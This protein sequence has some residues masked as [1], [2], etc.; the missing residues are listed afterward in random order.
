MSS[1]F[2]K[3]EWIMVSEQANEALAFVKNDGLNGRSAAEIAV[4][5]GCTDMIVGDIGD[6]ALGRLQDAK[7]HV[8]AAQLPLTGGEALKMFRDG[9]LSPV[10]A[11][12]AATRHGSG[13]GCC[14]KSEAGSEGSSCCR[15]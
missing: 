9:Q 15:G 10:P 3:A 1:H 12:R 13:H 4:N 5:Q 6:G 2:G 11:A 8:W 7:I 14:C